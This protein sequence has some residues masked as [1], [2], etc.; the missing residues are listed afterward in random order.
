MEDEVEKFW[1]EHGKD[2]PPEI[3]DEIDGKN[4]ISLEELEDKQ[5]EEEDADD[6][7]IADDNYDS[8]PDDDYDTSSSEE[9]N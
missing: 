7:Q 9:D 6:Q 3:E 4:V 2:V 1:S 5:A 8:D